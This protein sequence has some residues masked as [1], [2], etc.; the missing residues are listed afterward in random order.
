MERDLLNGYDTAS[1]VF[2]V[3]R[4]NNNNNNVLSM[5]LRVGYRVMENLGSDLIEKN[6]RKLKIY[7]W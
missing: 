3:I 2:A 4:N 6:F 7:H 1:S 5:V